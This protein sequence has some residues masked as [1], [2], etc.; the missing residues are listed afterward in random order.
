MK[1]GPDN[2]VLLEAPVVDALVA[3]ILNLT[4]EL[5]VVKER[6]D[7]V[8]RLLEA[9]GTLP[10]SDIESFSADPT[11]AAERA[12]ARMDLLK[13]VMARLEAHYSRIPAELKQTGK[14]S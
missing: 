7:T 3:T 8:E 6:L 1:A 4:G 2:V 5:S 14:E 11:A 12:A 9:K 13:T 10:R